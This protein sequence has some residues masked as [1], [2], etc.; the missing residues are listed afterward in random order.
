MEQHSIDAVATVKKTQEHFDRLH[1]HEVNDKKMN[2]QPLYVFKSSTPMAKITLLME[3]DHPQITPFQ[4]V[5]VFMDGLHSHVKDY[6]T[7]TLWL[8]NPVIRHMQRIAYMGCESENVY[9]ISKFLS[10]VNKMLHELKGDPN[11]TWN[12]CAIMTDDNAAN[13]IAVGNKLGEHLHKRTVS[14]QWHYLICAKK[15][16]SRVHDKDDKKR[17]K[18]IHMLLLGRQST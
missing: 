11:Y 10:L 13:K 15:Q 4:D 17:F 7:L 8:H 3:Q 1:I 9:N 12:P 14:C 2:G 5:V 16:S 6:I 18:G